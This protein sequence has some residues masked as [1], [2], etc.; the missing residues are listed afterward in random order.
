[1]FTGLGVLVCTGL[2]G[3]WSA[4]KDKDPYPPKYGTNNKQVGPG[5]QGTTRLPGQPGSGGVGLGGQPNNTFQPAGFNTTGGRSMGM[6]GGAAGFG[7]ANPGVGM[8]SGAGGLVPAMGSGAP[9]TGSSN[10]GSIPQPDLRPTNTMGSGAPAFG[11]HP[12]A[13]GLTDGA[14]ITPPVPPGS[15]PGHDV[16]APIPNYNYN[17]Q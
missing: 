8:G 5:L 10:F 7:S 6:N 9:A 3:C 1:V 11:N 17:R 16:N 14:S 13:V 15:P 12:P 4:D 2:V